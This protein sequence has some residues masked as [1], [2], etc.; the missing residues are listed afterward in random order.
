MDFLKSLTNKAKKQ[1]R[2]I[3][4]PEVAF[5]DRILK[6]VLYLGKHKICK[7]ILIGD[8]SSII[9]QN[10][11]LNNFKI[12]NPKTSSLTQDLAVEL[13]NAR[14]HKGLTIEQ[15]NELILDPFYFATMLVK[16]GYADGMVGGAEVSTARNLK[17]ALQLLKTQGNGFVNSYTM[18]VGK[19][20]LTSS[21]FFMTDC[22]LIEEPTLEQLPVMA[23]NVCKELQTFTDLS[24][25][26]A[27]LSYSTYGSAKSDSTIKMQQANIKFAENNPNIPSLGEIQIDAALLEP[28]AKHKLGKDKPYY[29]KANVLVFPD[30]N[31][32]NICYKAISYFGKLYA[33]GPITVG[34]DK[35]VNDL[36]RGCSVKDIIYLTAITVLQCKDEVKE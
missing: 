35:P 9:M 34:L 22:G 24:P 12:I 32:A 27:F 10:K 6:A 4:F 19:N 1:Q 2:A 16:C 3:V 20:D 15:A 17:P 31:S 18:F 7:P 11:K 13:Y 29:G 26:V 30:L 5:S 21:P 25:R 28:V 36:S 33:I 23:E 14:Q 8:E